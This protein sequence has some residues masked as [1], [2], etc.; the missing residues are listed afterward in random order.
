MGLGQ[1]LLTIMALMLM[2]RLILSV[3]TMTL[4]TGYT[5]DI[6]EYRITATSLGASKLEEAEGL[7]FDEKTVG[8]EVSLA[9]NLTASASLGK[10]AGE[11][12]EDTFNDIDDY[13]NYNKV[14][15]LRAVF[16]I[17]IKVEYVKVVSNV[18]TV[19]TAQTF[20][21]RITVK[22]TSD[23]LTDYSVEPP[24]RDTLSFQKILGYWYFR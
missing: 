1:T 12:T 14:D 16:N 3:N 6:A 5:K 11:S 18:V 7:A 22:V 15:T 4:D 13:N 19:S 24:R 23:Y 21:K 2:G 8:G 20:T 17:G 9:T 10:D